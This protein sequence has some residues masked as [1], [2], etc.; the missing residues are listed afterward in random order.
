MKDNAA[1]LLRARVVH[2]RH[3]PFRHR[4]EY[5][6]W[7]L[8][9]D[10]DRL[11]EVAARS[12]LFRAGRAGIV[13]LHPIDHGP[14]DGSPLR[15]WVEQLL[16]RSGL[17]APARVRL[18]AMP[19]VLGYVFNPISLYLCDDGAGNASAVIYQVKNTFG[20]QHC[21]VARLSGA[22]PHVHRAEKS[23]HVSPFLGMAARYDFT[24]SL[25]EERFGL[26]IEESENERRLLT[27]SMA[28]RLE[29]MTDR[30]LARALLSMPFVT[31]A[32]MAGIHAHALRLWLKG[33]RYHPRPA[34]PD[35][36][37][38]VAA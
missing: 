28:G 15:P 31:V 8:L 20:D 11:E 10:L 25:S 14:R 33:A 12:R 4:L 37:H 29:P 36:S 34:P 27:A 2:V 9:L 18:L 30:A 1:S 35:R 13:S 17:P 19:R 22:G 16:A 5:R 6:I 32:A 23:L 26:V 21:Y 3:V 24:L 38:S 7:S